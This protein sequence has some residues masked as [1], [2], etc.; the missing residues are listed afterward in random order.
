MIG[1]KATS[2]RS[3]TEREWH[4]MLES[5]Q[6]SQASGGEPRPSLLVYTRS[7][8]CSFEERLR[9]LLDEEKVELIAQKKLGREDE[10]VS[11]RM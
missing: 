7:D 9:G 11:I 6:N 2:F 5:R 8:E 4:L 3:G 10:I 1:K